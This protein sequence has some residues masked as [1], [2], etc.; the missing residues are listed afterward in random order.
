MRE[1][2]W[3]ERA[4]D[5]IAAH[6]VTPDEVEQLVNTQ[7]RLVVDGREDTEYVFGTTDA[8]RYLL[9]S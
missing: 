2:R 3:T 1:I 9:W 5:H 7:P 8:G 4:E 6:G